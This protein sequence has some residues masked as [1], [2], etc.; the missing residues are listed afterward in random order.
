MC[1]IIFPVYLYYH[2]C[3]PLHFLSLIFT[4]VGEQLSSG[5]ILFFHYLSYVPIQNHTDHCNSTPPHS[6]WRS[7]YTLLQPPIVLLSIFSQVLTIS[8]IQV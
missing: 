1:P 5:G 7:C 2:H 3:R 8:Y 4:G 6:S